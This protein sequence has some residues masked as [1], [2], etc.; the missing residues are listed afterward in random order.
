MKKTSLILLLGLLGSIAAFAVCY[1]AGTASTR[2]LMRQ[3]QPE[4][5]WLKKEFNLGDAEYARIV[6]L[7][8]AYLPKCAE[9]CRVIEQQSAKLKR[10]MQRV[11]A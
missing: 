2:E 10:L 11:P 5:A 1:F 4:L 7:H 3:P 9:R 6:A 8:Q